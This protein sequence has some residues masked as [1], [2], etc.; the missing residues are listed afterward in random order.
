MT[1]RTG[2]LE[3]AYQGTMSSSVVITAHATRGQS[4]RRKS[5]LAMMIARVGVARRARRR[6]RLKLF[7][8]S[9][10]DRTCP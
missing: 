8:K 7:R 5:L 9:V 6:P 3:T 4:L 10:G 2:V 1:K